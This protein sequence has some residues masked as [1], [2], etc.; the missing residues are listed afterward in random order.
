[1]VWVASEKIHGCNFSVYCDGD[2]V[3]YGRRNDYITKDIPIDSGKIDTF[4]VESF[5]SA[6]KIV[7][8]FHNKLGDLFKSLKEHYPTIK[9]YTLYGEYF[10]GN[11]IEK[12]ES[13]AK[14]VQ[15]GIKYTPNHE[16]LVFDANIQT[17]D[18]LSL[19]VD[20]LDL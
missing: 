14:P 16:Y 12:T 11:W 5:Y 4:F 18:G 15:T 19:W 13:K 10:G 6:P 2:I 17:T 7:S 1:M 3:K 20:A 9:N 8:G